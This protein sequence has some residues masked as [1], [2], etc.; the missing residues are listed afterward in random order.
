[1]EI[2]PPPSQHHAKMARLLAN[3]PLEVEAKTSIA[4]R[5]SPTFDGNSL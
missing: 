4:E 1:M 5:F 3:Q 2:K